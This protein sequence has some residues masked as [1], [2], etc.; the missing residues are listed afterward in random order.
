MDTEHITNVNLIEEIDLMSDE[1]LKSILE[2][3]LFAASEPI[4]I[5][6]FQSALPEV[7]KRAIRRG[8]DELWR[9]LRRDGTQL[10]PRR[11]SKWIPN[12]LKT[13]VFR[14]D[15]E[16]L[17]ADRSASRYLPPRLRRSLSLHTSSLS[18]APMSQ[19]FVVSIAIAYST[20]SLRKGLSVS[21][22]ERMD[23]RS[24]SQPPTNS[25]NNSD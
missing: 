3:I 6:Q 20:H 22:A 14:M 7:G 2:A 12:L 13:G 8:L 9:R 18:H 1:K 24:S 17:Y 5:D 21:P 4:S 10:S 19:R 25:F 15:R 23:A 11:N 16:I